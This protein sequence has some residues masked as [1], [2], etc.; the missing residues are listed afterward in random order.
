MPSAVL[1]FAHGSRFSLRRGETLRADFADDV[2]RGLTAAHK[3][4]PPR[5][6]Y[7][8]LGS[9]LFE[10]ICQLPEY[11]VT[12][13][14]TDVL[15]THAAEIAKAFGPHIRVTELGSG[16]AR[17]TRIL[18]DAITARQPELEYIPVD[19]DAGMLEASGQA[20]VAEYDAMR[21][22]AICA[23]FGR[24]STALRDS[25]TNGPRNIVLFLGSSIGNLDPLAAAA[26]LTDLRTVLAPGDALF[27]GADL[28]KAKT[29]LEPAY[30][31]PLG[32]TAAFN[33][34]VLARINRELGGHFDLR[35]FSHRAFYDQEHGRI[36]M[37]LVSLLDQLVHIDALELEIAFAETETI[38]TENS[39]KY[40]E[41]T[42]ANLAAAGGFAIEQTWTDR[43]DLFVDALLVAR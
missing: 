4:L 25:F 21:V 3:T 16:S 26:M 33:L 43:N 2:R 17:K 36:E 30:D 7:D 34:N 40:D 20:L 28:R 29:I 37:H 8:D 42:L 13:A 35:A 5:W 41:A 23:D 38:H 14:E 10:A 15:T 12:R 9:A 1:P 24:P 27:L 22:T 18:L 39:Y 11:Y 32:V 19:V 6:F 31:D